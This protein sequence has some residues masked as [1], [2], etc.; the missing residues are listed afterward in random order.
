MSCKE[1]FRMFEGYYG[2]YFTPSVDA[3]GNL[4]WTNNA[5]LPNP[6]PINI[7]GAPG[8]G[9][10]ISGLVATEADLPATAE[11]WTCYL[12]G[13][14]V[15][16]TVYTLNPNSGW[17]SLGQLASGPKGDPGAVYTPSVS[18]EGVISWT[19][20]G[21]LPN[22]EPVNIKGPKGD[23]GEGVPA[24]GTPGQVLTRTEDGTAWADP[25]GGGGTG[26]YNDLSNQPQIG[27]VTL[28]GNKTPAQ[29]GLVAAQQGAGL[30]PDTE[31]Q[32]IQDNADDIADLQGEQQQQGSDLQQLQT[33]VDA[34]EAVIPNQ[35]SVQNQLADK[36]FVNSSINSSTAFFRGSFASRAALLAVAWQT[37]DPTGA[38]YVSNNDYAYVQDDESQDDE[39][40][41][42][43][44]VLETG[45]QNNGW[46]PQF[47]V[48]ESPLT[49]A[50]VAALNSGATAALIAQITVNQTAIGEK[51]TAPNAPALDQYLKWNGTAW[52]AASLPIYNG[53]VT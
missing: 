48:N 10:E 24:G 26:N 43:L 32:Q 33:D 38:N 8:T 23:T 49:A 14:E 5:G 30:I 19:N 13:T 25:Q 42:Y 52:V 27:G 40:W 18:P 28:Q 17:I 21:D 20:D 1:V 11:D 9:L 16:Y 46:Q 22:P 53:G 50:Q 34:I 35:A 4:T 39:A 7:K 36:E 12:V 6:A 47:R 29:L 15:P 37:S 44:Y 51:I 31:R 45:G 3:D 2:P 41:R